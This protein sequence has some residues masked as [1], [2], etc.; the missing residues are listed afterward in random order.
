M[1]KKTSN[2]PVRLNAAIKDAFPNLGLETLL[3]EHEIRKNWQRIIGDSLSRKTLPARLRNKTL[4]VSVS[5][6]AWMNEL[7]FHKKEI[8]KKINEMLGK[9]VVA[10]I[11]FKP[12]SVKNAKNSVK[13]ESPARELTQGEKL[14]IEKVSSA[15]KD[16]ELKKALKKAMENAKRHENG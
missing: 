11:I 6:S 3:M 13:S 5:S 8:L 2:E 9:T 1:R 4:C 12:G 15:V 14:F 10:E 16:R 7:S